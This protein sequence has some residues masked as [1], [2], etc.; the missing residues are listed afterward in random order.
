M[1]EH[2]RVMSMPL[3]ALLI[4]TGFVM[5]SGSEHHRFEI[6]RPAMPAANQVVGNQCVERMFVVGAG[7]A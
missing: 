4:A 2:E 7:L 6:E 1:P 3:P 5:L